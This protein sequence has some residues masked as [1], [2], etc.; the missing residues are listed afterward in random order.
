[1]D[2]HTPVDKFHRGFSLPKPGKYRLFLCKTRTCAQSPQSCPHGFSP[3]VHIVHRFIHNQ[4][5]G[6]PPNVCAD[7]KN[8]PAFAGALE[9]IWKVCHCEAAGRGNP[10]SIRSRRERAM[11]RIAYGYGLPR[12]FAPRNDSGERCPV[13]LFM[14]GHE[15]PRLI[16]RTTCRCRRGHRPPGRA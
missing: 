3:V 9:R 1:M 12:R 13:L 2:L 7:V 11:L 4:S 14:P 6:F 16:C 10:F 5:P 8:A 15:M